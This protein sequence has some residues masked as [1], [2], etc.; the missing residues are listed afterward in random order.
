MP[1]EILTMALTRKFTKS[2][3]IFITLQNMVCLLNTFQNGRMV[4]LNDLT[5]EVPLMDLESTARYSAIFVFTKFMKYFFYSL[6][7]FDPG[8]THGLTSSF[9]TLL[10]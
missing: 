7:K 6:K 9:T 4:P 10:I 3:E 5:Q 1:K 8:F 2:C